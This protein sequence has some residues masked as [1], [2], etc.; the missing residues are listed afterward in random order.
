[1]YTLPV[2][3]EAIK[4]LQMIEALLLSLQ[5]PWVHFSLRKG[6]RW[7]FPPPPDVQEK[8]KNIIER[9]GYT[10]S[11]EEDRE[12][13]NQEPNV[14]SSDEEWILQAEREI[15]FVKGQG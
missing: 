6:R 12:E 8:G 2:Q 5:N 4:V 10:V 14:S 11:E 7:D 9:R 1:M 13:Y 3:S 15:S